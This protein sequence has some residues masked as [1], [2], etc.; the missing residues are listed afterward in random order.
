MGTQYKEGILGAWGSRQMPGLTN[1]TP[2]LGVGGVFDLGR[3]LS[4]KVGPKARPSGFSKPLRKHLSR[5]VK[6]HKTTIK[7]VLYEYNFI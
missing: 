1:S 7:R 5:Y 4:L 3:G 2:C 6:C